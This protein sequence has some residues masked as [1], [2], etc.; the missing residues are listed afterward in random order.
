LVRRIRIE[1]G[2][3]FRGGYEGLQLGAEDAVFELAGG[4]AVLGA[5]TPVAGQL[6]IEPVGVGQPF[7][8]VGTIVADVVTAPG[9]WIEPGAVS[10]TATGTLAIEGDL[11]LEPSSLAPS[12]LL[13]QLD[14]EAGTVVSDR[15]AVDGHVD[16]GN[17][18]LQLSFLGT[19]EEL[20]AAVS[21]DDVF[22][23][24]E[25]AD[26]IEGVLQILDFATRE[27]D[28]L[29]NGD[30]VPFR[31]SFGGLPGPRYFQVFYGPGSPYGENRVVLTGFSN[32]PEPGTLALVGLGTAAV[33]VHRRWWRR[34]RAA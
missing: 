14:S 10:G 19:L 25:A 26:P 29:E 34:A 24:V 13:L 33:A 2:A 4:A 11:T 12:R 18:I 5:G 28:P 21:P 15:V 30:F 7:R 8:G 23:V 3:L 22:A 9:L 31:A 32:V 6:R 27:T 1:T 16:L 20:D 17:A